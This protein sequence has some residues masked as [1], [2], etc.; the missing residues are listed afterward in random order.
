MDD[1]CFFEGR[2][3]ERL[4]RIAG[5]R[6]DAIDAVRGRDLQQ[7]QMC[8]EGFLAD[9][10]RIDPEEGMS[11]EFGRDRIGFVDERERGH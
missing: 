6:I 1:P 4:H 11:V 8:E 3:P 2:F 5:E 10:F 9:E 7:A